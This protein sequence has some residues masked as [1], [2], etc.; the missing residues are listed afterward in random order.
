MLTK[1]IKGKLIGIIILAFVVALTISSSLIYFTAHQALAENTEQ[2]IKALAASSSKETGLWLEE[3]KSYISALANTPLVRGD[4]QEA[5]WQYLAGEM[6]RAKQYEVLFVSDEKGDYFACTRN[7]DGS[8]SRRGS[9]IGDRPYF[10][11]VMKG[12]T[13]VSDPV[14]SKVTG[15]PVIVVAAPIR[16]EGRIVGV[17]GGSMYLDELAQRVSAIKVAKSGYAF[18]V[19]GD[20]QAIMHPD[21]NLVMKYNFLKE[22]NSDAGLREAIGQAA[23]GGKGVARYTWG[24]VSKYAGYAAVPGTNWGLLVSV[25]VAEVTEQLA[26]M[27]KISLLAPLAVA[28]III[29]VTGFFLTRLIIKPIDNLQTVMARVATGD[30]TARAEVGSDDEFGV[31][32]RAVNNTFDGLNAMIGDVRETTLKLKKASVGL[33]DISTTLAANSEEMSAKICTVSATVEQISANIEE[34]AS[35]TEEVSHGVDAVAGLANEMSAAA[36]VS[37]K[38]AETVALEVKQVSAVV[39]GISQSI[40]R[41]AA[42]AVDVSAAMDDVAN[43]VTVINQSLGQVSAKCERSIGITTEAA[44]RSQE[45]TAIIRRL[46]QASKQINGV[47]DIIRSIAE[48]TNMLALNATI[49]AAG[50]GEAGKGFAV[51]AAEVKELAKRTAEETRHIAQQIEEMQG[52]MGE[53]VIAVEKITGVIA[54]TK[55]ITHTIASAVAEQTKSATD[56][57]GAMAVGVQKVATISQE[58]GDIATNAGQVSQGAAGAADGVKAMFETTVEISRK[59]AEVASSSDKMASVMSN[60]A[61]AT[62]EIAQGAQ[63][64]IESIQEADAATADTAGKASLTSESAHYLG[65]AAN[66]LELLV[67]KFKV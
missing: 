49:E 16:K 13:I 11:E 17:M 3:K 32:M 36:Q 44:E 63:E 43:A 41:A 1:T 48:Q 20:G 39:E 59:S 57:S 47:V 31:L 56:I 35:S 67:E 54:E 38:T 8:I 33:I 52:D 66:N 53:A 46:S 34:T 65:E 15:H 21:K 27:T 25:P 29:F 64:I 30:F 5:I 9:N 62:K 12:K 10:P 51:V 7:S 14:Y 55:D 45:T 4:D 22:G 6:G 58:I 23:R 40:S 60:I 2:S 61:N 42:S 28:L 18:V 26:T 50:A 19:Q 37:A 24:D